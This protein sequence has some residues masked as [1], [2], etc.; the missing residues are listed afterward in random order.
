VT[1]RVLVT[2]AGGFLGGHL[3]GHLAALGHEVTAVDCKP[4]DR[5]QQRW[6]V[7][8]EVMD[9]RDPDC[10]EKIA[11]NVSQVY[12]LAADMGGVGYITRHDWPCAA[13]ITATVN[14]LNAAGR[15]GVPL[16]VYTSSACVYPAS[17]QRENPAPLAEGRAMPSAPEGGYGWEKLFSERLCEYAASEFG[18][19]VRVARLFN[20]Y[21]PFTDWQSDRAK[22]PAAICR[23]VARAALFPQREVEIWG[24]G[25]QLL[26]FLYASDCVDGLVALA[27]SQVAAPVNLASTQVV[28]IRQ[29]A[30]LIAQ[31]AGVDIT[32]R[33][34]DSQPT[35]VGARIP[36]ISRARQHLQWAPLVALAEGV[37]STYRW[38]YDQVRRTG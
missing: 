14:M 21:G 3:V 20:V 10:C 22:A 33:F 1:D 29:L 23:K 31:V 16:F 26:S 12:H 25:Q 2:G 7:Q 27:R 5:W 35:G 30:E 18:I 34:N 36:D 8:C 38:I 15:E 32:F 11:G 28:S 19:G 13:S 9:L 24:T 6:D 37:Q 4:L 17:L